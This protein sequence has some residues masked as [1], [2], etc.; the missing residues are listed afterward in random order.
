[1]DSVSVRELRNHG[2]EVLDKVARGA[3]LAVTR[4]GTEVAE[5]RPRPRR[6]P[7][8][9]ELVARRRSLPLVDPDGDPAGP[10][11]GPAGPAG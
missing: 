9:T 4:D 8:P 7:S 2:G 5:L 1:M 10:P 11:V 6:G 3:V